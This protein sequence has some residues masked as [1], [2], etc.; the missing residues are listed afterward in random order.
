MQWADTRCSITVEHFI[1]KGSGALVRAAVE[2]GVVL[3]VSIGDEV[4]LKLNVLKEA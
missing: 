1:P 3:E 2:S 4:H